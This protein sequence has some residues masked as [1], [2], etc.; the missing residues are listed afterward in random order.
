MDLAT[1]AM[2]FFCVDYDDVF[3]YD[4]MA[5]LAMAMHK[6]DN[7]VRHSNGGANEHNYMSLTSSV[8]A[9]GGGEV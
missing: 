4:F 5:A 6:R 9:C 2:P 8:G 1:L 3:G 7:G